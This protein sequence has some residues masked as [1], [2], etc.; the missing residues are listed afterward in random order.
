[1]VTG[2]SVDVLPAVAWVEAL[3]EFLPVGGLHLLPE[4]YA[5]EAAR[6]AGYR[7]GEWLVEDIGVRHGVLA[8]YFANRLFAAHESDAVTLKREQDAARPPQGGRRGR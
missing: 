4:Y 2:L 1:M 3:E 8:H 6:F 7:W 5:R